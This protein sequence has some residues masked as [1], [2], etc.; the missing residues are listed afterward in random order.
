MFPIEMNINGMDW[1]ISDVLEYTQD[2]SSVLDSKSSSTVQLA[3]LA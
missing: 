1:K 2:H 3:V